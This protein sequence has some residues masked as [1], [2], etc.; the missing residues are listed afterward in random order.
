[1]EENLH[2]KTSILV[3]LNCPPRIQLSMDNIQLKIGSKFKG[4]KHIPLGTHYLYYSLAEEKHMFKVGFFIFAKP[5]DVIVKKW[6]EELQDFIDIDNTE[7]GGRFRSSAKNLELDFYLAAYPLE[8]ANLW[9]ELSSYITP[10]VLDKLEPIGKKILSTGAEYNNREMEEEV[11]GEVDEKKEAKKEEF[12]A[13]GGTI[14]FTEIP[15]KHVSHK[16]TPEEITKAN[17]DKTAILR[18][19]IEKEY[20]KDIK[21]FYGEM[22]FAFITFILGESVEGFEQWKKMIILMA[23]ADELTLQHAEIFL[24]FIPILYSQLQQFPEDFFID[25]ISGNNFMNSCLENILSLAQ[26]ERVDN[27]LR[28]RVRKLESMLKEKFKFNKHNDMEQFDLG[29]DAPV[30]VEDFDFIKFD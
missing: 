28:G 5:G 17:F 13:I 20:K 25:A 12:N 27:K 2:A 16:A 11:E 21:M 15:T 29:E 6:D 24:E 19:L 26:D 30:I 23:F 22:Q 4:I 1:M 14:Y 7:E 8:R 10:D 3:L 18:Q 9:K